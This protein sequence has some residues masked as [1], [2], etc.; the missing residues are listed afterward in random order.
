MLRES[1]CVQTKRKAMDQ[2]ANENIFLNEHICAF[3]ENI[4]SWFVF[5]LVK[6][7]VLLPQKQTQTSSVPKIPFM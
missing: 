6:H 5:F 3:S 7:N 4:L 2:L 1:L